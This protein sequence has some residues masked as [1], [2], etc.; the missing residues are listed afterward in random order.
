MHFAKSSALALMLSLAACS[1]NAADTTATPAPAAPMAGMDMSAP[2]QATGPI[3]SV[4]KITAIDAAAGTVTL[5]HQ[6]IPAVQWD[7]MTMAFTAADPTMLKDLKVGD[8]VTF[9]LKSAA[10]KTVVIKIQKQ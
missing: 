2:V 10:E 9:E 4:G 8:A 1:P 7:A 6:A 3:S 5:D